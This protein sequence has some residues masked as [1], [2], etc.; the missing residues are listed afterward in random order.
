[1]QGVN[2]NKIRG[3]K[4]GQQRVR[5]AVAMESANRLPHASHPGKIEGHRDGPNISP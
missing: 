1:M 3:G 5:E 4:Q 2:M